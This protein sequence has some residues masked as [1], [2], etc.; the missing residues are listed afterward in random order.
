MFLY[1]TW[2]FLYFGIF[3]NITA[4][5]GFEFKVASHFGV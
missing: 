1:S 5:D 3:E 2:Y 4:I